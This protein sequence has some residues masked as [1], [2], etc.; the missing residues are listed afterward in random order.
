MKLLCG[1]YVPTTG[2]IRVNGVPVGDFKPEEYYKL[3]APVF[4]DT[5]TGPFTILETVTGRTEGG[6]DRARAEVCLRDAGL[7]DKI[8]SL[9]KGM[10]TMLDK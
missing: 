7:G 1:L 5:G 10:D 6:G 8:D 4:Q 9:P 2:E 3:F